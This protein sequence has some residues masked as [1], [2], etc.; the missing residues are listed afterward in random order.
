MSGADKGFSGLQRLKKI[1]VRVYA[2]IAAVI[3]MVIAMIADHKI[4]TSYNQSVVEDVQINLREIEALVKNEYDSYR[5]DI[6]FL[7][8]TP[9]ISGLTR[10]AKNNGIDPLDGTTIAKWR[11]RLTQI[12]RSFTENNSQYFQLRLLDAQ[13]NETVRVERRL[14]KIFAVETS[15]L[16]AKGDRYYFTSTKTLS[17]Q[18]LFV[19]HIDLNHEYGHIAF[20]HQ[21]TLRIALPVFSENQ[22]FGQLIANIDV[23]E[24]LSELD[25][26]VGE[27]LT[28]ILTDKEQYFVKHPDK[29]L[30]FSRDL[31]PEKTFNSE[32]EVIASEIAEL[33]RYVQK[34]AGQSALGLSRDIFVSAGKTGFLHAY[35]LVNEDYYQNQ[36]AERR[37][38]SMAGLGAVLLVSLLALRYLGANNHRL[39]KLLIAAEEAKAAVDVA[40]DAVI[41]VNHEWQITSFNKAFVHMFLL[42]KQEIS[43]QKITELLAQIGGEEVAEVLLSRLG[44]GVNG[45]EWQQ[46]IQGG[47]NMWFHC[48]V[49]IVDNPQAKAAYAIVIR[50]ITAEK[51]SL[52]MVAENNQKLEKQVADRTE[53]LRKSR[54][55]AVE[56]SQLKSNF[57]S[58]ISH[59]MRTPLN[60]IVGATTLLRSESLNAKQAKLLD[61]AQSS[62]DTLQRLINDVLDLSKIE[63]G[64]LELNFRNFNPEALIEGITSTMSVVANQKGIGFY[65]DTSELNFSLI[66]SDPHRLTQVINNVLNNAIK[67]TSEGYVLL[68]CRGEGEDNEAR[69]VI[70]VTDTG[71]G[72]ASDQIDKLFTA[73]N[74]ADKTIAAS[75]GGTGLGLSIC[76]EILTLLN[77]SITVTSEEGAGT[78]FTITV[79]LK[80]WQVREEDKSRLAGACAGMMVS[81]EP[82]DKVLQQLL[83]CNGAS[84]VVYHRPMSLAEVQSCGYLFV[85]QGSVYYSVFAEH[86]RQWVANAERL[87]S[88]FVIS[89][90][91]ADQSTL[92]E[93][94]TVLTE[95]LYRSVF[96]SNVVDSRA[97]QTSLSVQ[98]SDSRRSSDV[99]SD[100]S[101]PAVDISAQHFLIVDDNEINRQVAEFILEPYGPTVFSAV[102]GADAIEQLRNNPDINLVLMDC[103]MPV[104]NGYDATRAIRGGQAGEGHRDI[105]II[106]MT[107]NALK[108]ESQKCYEAGMNNYLTKPIDAGEFIEKVTDS[109][110]SAKV[111]KMPKQTHGEPAQAIWQCEEA[112][113]RLDNNKALL[114]KLLSLFTNE[115]HE[116]QETL[117]QAIAAEDREKVRFIAHA[118]KGNAGDVGAN[119]L[120]EMLN[121]LEYQA[122]T[123]TKDDMLA[124]YERI[125]LQL[126][127]LI[128]QFEQFI[129]ES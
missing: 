48:K 115:S 61:M 27:H 63:A 10:A 9:P 112:L 88:L 31:A 19:S 18:Q 49:N 84:P 34:G 129:K 36:L 123:A 114:K 44:T 43:G 20:P 104:L 29:S 78:T 71:K 52:L 110:S 93:Q 103:N 119:T 24:L 16:Q 122:K 3:I 67:F 14:G 117:A 55:E 85:E 1:S 109:L 121:E 22:F 60:G 83:V 11:S 105:P 62:V 82:L 2:L 35:V 45:V 99:R 73:F 51:E 65:I 91:A 57:I 81:S 108:G 116:K 111:S 106:A 6:Y 126:P 38:E 37:L 124:I 92:Q 128:S 95:P 23:S 77:G 120:K 40:E 54:D 56:L 41:T 127:A 94:A 100:H 66:H 70:E 74:Q 80:L 96:L 90:S 101:R 64:K 68:T 97:K 107:A 58:T 33:N 28:I 42:Q 39:S 87:P 125:V 25:V 32:Y 21:P 118:F 7:H 17:K 26:L 98:T 15:D 5:D 13:G 50:D 30:Q 4:T 72:I 75:Y 47:R 53:E 86:W 46:Q 113:E 79:P 59:E 12:F 89:Q 69:L 102:N 8:D 76:R